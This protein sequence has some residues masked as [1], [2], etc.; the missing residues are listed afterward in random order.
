MNNRIFLVVMCLA[1]K[2]S[3]TCEAGD[4]PYPCVAS[5]RG[6]QKESSRVGVGTCILIAPSW[7]LTA[8]HVASPLIKG[9]PD[10]EIRIT[11]PGGITRVAISAVR[12]TD[13]DIALVKL[14]KP[15]TNIAPIVLQSIPLTK[16]DHGLIPLVI[17]GTSGGRK[18]LQGHQAF[19]APPLMYRIP[20]E[21]LTSGKSGDSGGAW[22]LK[23]TDDSPPLLVAVLSGGVQLKGKQYGRGIQPSLY[24]SW[25]DATLATNNTAA[26]WKE[27]PK[28]M[29]EE[30]RKA[31]QNV[32]IELPVAQNFS[33]GQIAILKPTK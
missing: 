28:N 19:G 17:V 23:Q 13:Q 26:V 2:A 18:V 14:D 1:A 10:R 16:Q 8:A 33:P 9:D 12:V 29:I 4:D 27:I 32:T 20:N 3:L 25:I 5:W 22:I 31:A 11:F 24:R 15:V 21:T 6:H 30:S 7:V